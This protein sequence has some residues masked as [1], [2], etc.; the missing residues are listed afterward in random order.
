[1]TTRHGS[2]TSPDRGLEP[3]PSRMGWLRGIAAV[4]FVLLA[5]PVAALP[6]V[7]NPCHGK[8]S[9]NAPKETC[10][11]GGGTARDRAADGNRNG[12]GN[13]NGNAHGDDNGHTGGS[14]NGGN[15]NAGGGTGSPAGGTTGP[16]KHGRKRH[17]SDHR[18]SEGT[19][20]GGRR[21]R[22]QTTGRQAEASA[23]ASSSRSRLPNVLSSMA[24][25]MPIAPPAANSATDADGD[26]AG[27]QLTSG[28]VEVREAVVGDKELW[29]T[30]LVAAES[31]AF[32]M[33][34]SL[35]VGLFLIV[36]AYID[37]NDPKMKH[38]ALRK[39]VYEFS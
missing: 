8:A 21:R 1:M 17:R 30:A 23:G 13:G 3:R 2:S 35:L 18:R 9:K 37:R 5:V 33:S 19:D 12:K 20:D 39:E 25:D 26:L 24:T 34:L 36:Q 28:L 4:T 32:P 10:R 6:A 38:A 31:L 16:S 7:A 27:P 15:E 11:S 29:S 22:S 14:N